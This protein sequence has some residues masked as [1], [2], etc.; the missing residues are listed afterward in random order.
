LRLLVGY[1]DL[2]RKDATFATDELR[3]SMAGHVHD[4]AALA[5][6]ANRDTQ[7]NALSA[8]A[9]ARLAAA[10]AHIADS[11]VKPGLTVEAVARR[12][13]ISRRY[14]QRLLD[15]SGTSFTA[16]VNELRLYASPVGPGVG[17]DACPSLSVRQPDL[18]CLQ[19]PYSAALPKTWA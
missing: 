10:L 17:E 7:Q 18:L 14:L 16:R 3:R 9:A 15:Q 4:L 19:L 5:L 13:G 2:L 12:Q 11:F 1:L 6:G 8:V